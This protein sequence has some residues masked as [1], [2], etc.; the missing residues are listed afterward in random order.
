MES[1]A[2][3]QRVPRSLHISQGMMDDYEEGGV[4]VGRSTP[5]F[6]RLHPIRRSQLIKQSMITVP[7]QAGADV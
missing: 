6:G 7:N 5:I 4:N 1:V 3:D 2:D